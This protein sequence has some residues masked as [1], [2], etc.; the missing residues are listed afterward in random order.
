MK[1]KRL[2]KGYL[3]VLLL[4]AVIFLCGSN[5]YALTPSEVL[6]KAKSKIE[7]A[8]S[9]SADFKMKINGQTVSGKIKSKGNKFS[10]ITNGACHWYNGTDL[11]TYNPSAGETTIFRPTKQELTEVNPLLYLSTS[12]NYNIQATKS[13]TQGI[14]T[15]M[16]VPK[17]AGSVKNVAM[18]LDS[19]SFLP[20]SIK[21][22]PS[23]GGAIDIQITNI[24]LNG[25]IDN[26]SFEYPKAS[27]PKVKIN[28]M[29]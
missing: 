21:I 9:I 7:S 29:R 1:E 22:L 11:Y 23:S 18:N 16:M 27:Y 3:Y 2:N 14:E 12:T 4:T 26:S 28:D 8:K 20:K 13:K 10:I 15:V 5:V 19:K 24:K 25:N 6:Q 17:K